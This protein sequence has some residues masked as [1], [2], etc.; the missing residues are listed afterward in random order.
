MPHLK[1]KWAPQGPS[2][3][4]CLLSRT[5]LWDLCSLLPP[6]LSLSSHPQGNRGG[7]GL[8]GKPAE[9]PRTVRGPHLCLYQSCRVA[10]LLSKHTHVYQQTKGPLFPPGGPSGS[11]ACSGVTPGLPISRHMFQSTPASEIVLLFLFAVLGTKHRAL[12]MLSK[13]STTKLPRLALNLQSLC[14]NLQNS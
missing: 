10:S 5:P 13:R 1:P 12:C 14:L 9:L 4:H 11:W 2:G 7:T 8:L 3:S 6:L